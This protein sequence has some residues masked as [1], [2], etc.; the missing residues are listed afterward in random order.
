MSGDA[1]EIPYPFGF[2]VPLEVSEDFV[3]CEYFFV[4][5]FV[6]GYAEFVMFGVSRDVVLVL[7][8]G[9]DDFRS[10]TLAVILFIHE[11]CTAD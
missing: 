4:L 10:K 1:F 3:V 9:T 2:V 5:V 8:Y 7:G 11:E 6:D